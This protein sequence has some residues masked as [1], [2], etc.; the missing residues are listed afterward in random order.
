MDSASDSASERTGNLGQTLRIDGAGEP[1]CPG[2]ESVPLPSS[3]VERPPPGSFFSP[4]GGESDRADTYSCFAVIGNAM[5]VSCR[6]VAS[7]D[8]FG[9]NF[10]VFPSRILREPNSTQPGP[11]AVI[12]SRCDQENVP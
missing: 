7:P 4:R 6:D 12:V 9:A 2:A 1:T 10:A 8:R 5:S 3:A 11:V